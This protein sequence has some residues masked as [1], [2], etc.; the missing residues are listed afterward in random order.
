[1]DISGL[2]PTIVGDEP[3]FPDNWNELSDKARDCYMELDKEFHD[4]NPGVYFRANIWA[5]RPIHMAIYAINQIFRL[6][7]DEDTIDGMGYNSGYGIKDQE[8][9]NKVAFYLEDM[10]NDM[11]KKGIHT[12]GFNMGSWT[13]KNG[14]F[15]ELT[16]E[17]E[18]MLN[19]QYKPDE[20]I[21][22]LPVKLAT[23]KETEKIYPS[24]TTEIKHVEE[25]I[26]FLRYCGGF[27]VW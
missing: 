15:L 20:L 25:F 23:R 14:K 27:E 10:M 16:D 11:K 22:D 12:F 26:Q 18:D 2:N 7:I 21:T 17:E 9:C 24:H 13:A 1:M 6:D 3:K 4:N 8:T 19:T 5:W